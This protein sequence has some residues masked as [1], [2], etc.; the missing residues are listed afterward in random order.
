MKKFTILA[1]LALTACSAVPVE[2]SY[3]R[4]MNGDELEQLWQ[5]EQADDRQA[6]RDNAIENTLNQ[7]NQNIIRGNISNLYKK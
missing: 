4:P 7:I 2:T 6:V 5:R 1:A 3:S